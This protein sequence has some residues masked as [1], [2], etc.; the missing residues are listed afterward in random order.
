M[1]RT[2]KAT[3]DV[4]ALLQ[5]NGEFTVRNW[6]PGDR[7][8]PQHSKGPKKVKELLTGKKITGRERTLWPVVA[9]GDRIVWLRGWGV[10]ADAVAAAGSEG[11]R[12]EELVSEE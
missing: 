3:G 7:F 8:Y 1:L 12:I 4:P 11:V 2:S 6:R 5:C 9:A 10:A